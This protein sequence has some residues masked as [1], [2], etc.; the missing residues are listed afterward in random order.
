MNKN[1]LLILFL[2]KL[3]SVYSY[4]SINNFSITRSGDHLNT[5]SLESR[6]HKCIGAQEALFLEVGTMFE[7]WLLSN[8][9]DAQTLE[10][11]VSLIRYSDDKDLLLMLID[12]EL[13]DKSLL[14]KFIDLINKGFFKLVTL[15]KFE[16]AILNSPAHLFERINNDDLMLLAKAEFFKTLSNELLLLIKEKF[17]REIEFESYKHNYKSRIIFDLSNKLSDKSLALL[18][19]CFKIKAEDIVYYNFDH[20]ND[21]SLLEASIR[22]GKLLLVNLIL[23]NKTL[24]EITINPNHYIYEQDVLSCLAKGDSNVGEELKKH[25][26]FIDFDSMITVQN[27][28]NTLVPTTVFNK[29]LVFKNTDA[30]ALRRYL[31]KLKYGPKYEEEEGGVFEIYLSP[32]HA[33]MGVECLDC[34]EDGQ[35]VDRKFGFYGLIHR[36]VVLNLGVA[37]AKHELSRKANV[38]SFAFQ[39]VQG[40][41]KNE[42]DSLFIS[43]QLNKPKIKIYTSKKAIVAINAMLEE[44]IKACDEKDFE[45]CY[46]QLFT[47]NCVGFV[48]GIYAAQG[49]EGDYRSLF[50][51]EQ[52]GFGYFQKLNKFGDFYDHKAASYAYLMSRPGINTLYNLMYALGG[53]ISGS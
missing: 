31:L 51:D 46:Y 27:G 12:N 23:E 45:N 17:F 49:F 32:G 28:C 4:A 29:L 9:F 35:S 20:N 30:Q 19:D 21:V 14:N 8:N 52:L 15:K 34:S 36:I 7:Q 26:D 5:H 38:P 40:K 48:Q 6:S 41:I 50:T 13:N 47:N 10:P 11:L 18:V 33:F 22:E 42:S 2:V 44:T 53:F 37:L 25:L 16:E 39:Y 3:I 1:R 43:N 24:D